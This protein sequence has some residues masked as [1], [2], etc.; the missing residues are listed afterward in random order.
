MKY[1]WDTDICIYWLKG[2]E[3]IKEKVKE[4]GEDSI[5]I[6]IITLAEL[7]FG[8]YNSQ[9]VK[10]NLKVIE[11]FLGKMK[12]LNLDENSIDKYGEIKTKLRRSGEL[13]EDFDILIA[14]IVIVNNAILV[15]NNVDHFKRIEELRI[16]NWL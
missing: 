14:S 2:Y 5:N 1:V 11:K 15:T 12:V 16:E 6:T 8:A 4:V 9:K 7:K 13:I 3:Q 10:E